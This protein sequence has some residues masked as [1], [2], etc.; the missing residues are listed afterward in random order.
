MAIVGLEI[1]RIFPCAE[2]VGVL[3]NYLTIKNNGNKNRIHYLNKIDLNR[4]YGKD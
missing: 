1:G 4:I 2:S 3:F